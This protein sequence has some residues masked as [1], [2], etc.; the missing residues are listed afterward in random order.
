[1]V[2][3][4]LLHPGAM[5]ESIGSALANSSHS[6][7]WASEGRSAASRDR[8][9]KRGLEDVGTIQ[10]LASRCAVIICVCPPEAAHTVAKAVVEDCGY[11]GLYVDGNAISPETASTIRTFVQGCGAS[12]VDG[13]I[14]GPPAWKEGAMRFYL[15]GERADEVANLFA[16]TLVDARV[17]RGTGA[18][19]ASALKVAYAGWTKASSALLVATNA[20]AMSQGVHGALL[21]EWRISQPHLDGESH[22]KAAGIG[23]KAWRFAGEMEEISAAYAAEG[24]PGGFHS[25]AADIFTRL[26]HL[27]DSKD[28]EGS[29]KL[30]NVGMDILNKKGTKRKLASNL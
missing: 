19:A 20:Y 5:G 29:L 24:L 1:M 17:L 9:H 15:S 23:P 4:G 12:Y 18:C 28:T 21:T 7:L 11:R 16:D 10:E 13:G 30:E 8:A 3:V 26:T 27:K 14:I 2:V 25:A 6:C 22:A